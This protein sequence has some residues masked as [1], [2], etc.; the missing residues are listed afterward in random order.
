MAGSLF[1][2]LS[3]VKAEVGTFC[4]TRVAKLEP[5]RKCLLLEDPVFLDSRFCIRGELRA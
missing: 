1:M 2:P 3:Y 5:A 4:E